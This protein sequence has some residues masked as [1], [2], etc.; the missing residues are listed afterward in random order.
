MIPTNVFVRLDESMVTKLS[1]WWSFS[2]L[3]LVLVFWTSAQ[4]ATVT[5]T[6]TLSPSSCTSDSSNG[7][8]GSWS[9]LTSLASSDNSYAAVSLSPSQVSQYLNCQGFGFSIPSDATINGITLTVERRASDASRITDDAVRLIKAGV[10]G[11]TDLSSSTSYP[12][13]DTDYTYGGASNL[14]GKS[15]TYSDINSANFGVAIAVRRSSNASSSTTR[16]LLDYIRI[17]VTYTVPFCTQPTNTPSGLSLT[18]VCDSFNR[19]TLNPST[20][21]DSNWIVSTSDSTN[22]LPRIVTSGYLRLTDNTGY[23]AKAVTVPAAFPAAGNYISVE[24]ENY[25]YSGSGADGIAMTL[26][27]YSIPAVPGAYGGSLGYAQRSGIKG[28]TGGWIGIALDEYGNY[29]N[30]TEGRLGGPGFVTQ[31]IAARG[32]GSGSTG[33]NWLAGTK[34]LSP[35][36]DNNS[37]TTAAPGHRYQVIVDARNEPSSTS[38]YVNRDAGAGYTQLFSIPNVYTT[39]KTN[40]FTQAAV[41][42]NWQISFTGSTGGSTN[43]HEISNLQICAQTIVSPTGGVAGSFNA[44][45]DAYGT[46]AIE[47]QNYLTG[48][49]YMKVVGQPFKL[50]VAALNNSQIQTSYVLSGT[51]NVTV[52]LVDNSDEACVLDSAKS[53]YCSATCKAK[54]AVSGGSQT[55]AFSASDDGQKQSA[56]F[57]INTAYKNLVAIISDSTTTACS[58]DAFSVRPTG[59]A[60]VVSSN[61]TQSTTSGTPIFKAGGDQFSLTATISGISGVLSG[62]TGQPK[63]D[64]SAIAAVSPAT[65]SGVIAP[66]VFGAATSNTGSATATTSTFTYSEVGAFTLAGYSPSSDSTSAR[67]VYDGVKTSSEC[68]GSTT[69]QCDSLK[70]TS[71]WTGIDSVSTSSDC[72]SDS[73]SNTKVNGKYGCNFGL[74][75]TSAA[76]GRFVPYQFTVSSPVLTNRAAAFCS[77]ASSFSYL[78]EAMGL[79]FGLQ[80]RNATGAVTQNYAGALAKLTLNADGREL[81]FGAATVSPFAAISSSR[82]SGS[83]YPTAWPSFGAA[84]AGTVTMSG[85]VTV[86]SLTSSSNNRVSPD[87]PWT[88]LVLGIA[89]VDSDGTKIQTYD[90]ATVNASTLDHAQL[91][92]TTLYFGELRLLPALGSERLPLTMTAQMLRWNGAAFVPNGDDSCTSVPL[93][94][95]GLS[96]WKNNLSVGETSITSGALAIA[97]GTG[98]IKLSAPGLGNNGS[99]LVSADVNSAGLG[100]LE[101]KGGGATKY[102]TNPSA[103]ASFGLYKGSGAVIYQRE[104]Y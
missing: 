12:T 80:A 75:A 64:K 83:G 69:A 84:D 81:N 73:Y 85:L 48:H 100:Y 79:S 98:Q 45:D 86:S 3:L 8:G 44:I 93:S 70:L 104:L 41:P 11:T 76:I 47:V 53:N 14:W 13:S 60:S 65:V 61:A 63:I 32:S 49:I 55:L 16:V 22:I 46:P 62:Y 10:I 103:V 42:D 7:G 34:S 2:L 95:L 58:T 38:V 17:T 77:P 26:S 18:C 59:I 102:S 54:S 36:V 96:N 50:N 97:G 37:S 43:I 101:I 68:S 89:P 94:Y 9:G 90:L 99:V 88:N 23:N 40:G 51:K 19:S 4:A 31:S 15:W 91:A 39:A 30:P 25:A 52:K 21:F 82:I 57:T 56:D 78:D 92:S 35:D 28:F 29:Q 67:A 5:R 20:I 24:F 1:R 71:S 6:M 27:D 72:V 33:Y 87:G 74:V 66:A